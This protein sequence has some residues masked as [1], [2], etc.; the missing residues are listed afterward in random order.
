MTAYMSGS[1][2]R[3]RIDV[4]RSDP[5]SKAGFTILKRNQMFCCHLA[6]D[7][8]YRELLGANLLRAHRHLAKTGLSVAAAESEWS[9]TQLVNS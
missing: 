5:A 6:P 2:I 8:L 4:L 1:V 7:F 9:V 3:E